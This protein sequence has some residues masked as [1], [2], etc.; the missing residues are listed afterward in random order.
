MFNTVRRSIQ[1]L[2]LAGLTAFAVAPVAAF[3]NN[4]GPELPAQCWMVNVDEGHKLAFHVYAKGVQVY[5]W[6]GMAWQFEEPRAA[7][8]AEENYFGEIGTHFRGPNWQS[9]SGSRVKATA[10]PGAACTPDPTA[11]SWLKLAADEATGPGIFK[12][13]TFIQRVNTKGGLR[14][15]EPGTVG[16]I[17]EVE[18]TAEYYFYR[19]ENPNGN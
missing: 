13:I 5:K 9:K 6:N 16:E 17:R 2:I 7:L 12:D 15:T 4:N 18:Y 14:P 10:V 1:I 3:G 11:I 19:A 8:F